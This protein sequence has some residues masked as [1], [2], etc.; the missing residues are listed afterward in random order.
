MSEIR[1]VRRTRN[2]ALEVAR[3]VP[4]LDHFH[5]GHPFDLLES[6]VASWLVSQPEILQFVF[7]LCKNARVIVYDGGKWRGTDTQS[8]DDL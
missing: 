4:V 1:L 2:S 3:R 5:K 8:E 7:N 6:D